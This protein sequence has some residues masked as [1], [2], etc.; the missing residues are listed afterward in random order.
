MVP[1]PVTSG[2]SAGGNSEHSGGWPVSVSHS[3]IRGPVLTCLP[4]P[5]ARCAPRQLLGLP[6]APGLRSG[7]P[8]C[9]YPPH[10]CHLRAC[11]QGLVTQQHYLQ[12]SQGL[13][14]LCE[15]LIF[16][17]VCGVFAENY[18]EVAL[19]VKGLKERARESWP[20]SMAVCNCRK[21]PWCESE[22]VPLT[23]PCVLFC[24]AS[25][26]ICS[27]KGRFLAHL[28]MTRMGSPSRPSTSRYRAV[29]LWVLPHTPSQQQISSRIQSL[30]CRAEDSGM[31]LASY[32]ALHQGIGW[33]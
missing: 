13:C 14:H 2:H 33:Q 17:G 7:P 6:G 16:I 28:L 24:R 9:S 21:T 3:W 12:C 10:S 31:G 8:L 15:Y 20:F 26:K 27:R 19:A 23:P 30:H 29:C 18:T 1:L 11:A 5:P 25:M 4:P 22:V 32:L